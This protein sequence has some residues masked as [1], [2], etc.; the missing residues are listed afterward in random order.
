M[1]VLNI[2][3]YV[4]FVDAEVLMCSIRKCGATNHNHHQVDL[5]ND[6]NVFNI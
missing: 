1:V 3:N 5:L 6:V 2:N 4:H